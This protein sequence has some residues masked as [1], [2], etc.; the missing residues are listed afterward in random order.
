MSG[1]L[2]IYL[3]FVLGIIVG[4]VLFSKDFR[5][6]FFRGFRRFLAGV[7]KS[8]MG[9]TS[10]RIRTE[11]RN[12]LRQRNEYEPAPELMPTNHELLGDWEL[13]FK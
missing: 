3:V 5:E 13:D 4:G 2:G 9:R 12:V 8:G 11:S 7:G 6:K 1:G 10:S